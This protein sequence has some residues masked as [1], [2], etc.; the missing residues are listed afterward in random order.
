MT[1]IYQF[2]SE[3]ICHD[4]GPEMIPFFKE[5]DPN[6]SLESVRPQQGFKP[7]FQKLRESK[8]STDKALFELST[9]EIKNLL[10]DSNDAQSVKSLKYTYSKLD[11]LNVL[12]LKSLSDCRFCGWQCGVNR[13]HEPGKCGLKEKFYYRQPFIHI[14]EE[15]NINPAIVANFGG[16]AMRCRYCIDHDL[17][18]ADKLGLVES[19]SFWQR[20]RQLIQWEHPINTLEFTNP[21]ESLP[22]ILHLL[23]H[24]PPDFNLPI[25]FN[26]HLYCA[27]P[28][29]EIASGIVDVWL[30]DFPYGNN[31]CAKRLSGVDDYLEYV[32]YGLKAMV[33][34]D[35]EVVVRILVLPGHVDCCHGSSIRLLGIFKDKICVSVLD[36]FV[37]EY[38]A[39]DVMNVQRGVSNTEVETL[40]TFL[41]RYGILD[42]NACHY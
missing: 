30:P 2:G 9:Q 27:L 3:V 17:W 25:V 15:P 34:S 13:Y 16:C 4:P 10:Q 19:K 35:A 42:V 37:P 22:A 39:C 33:D 11:L 29:Y 5:I 26:C 32:E 23:Q 20:V 41:R 38:K 1:R 8:I 40:R 7:R 28:F 21:T 31:E 12:A 36:Q 24:A 6:Y 18:D 14:A